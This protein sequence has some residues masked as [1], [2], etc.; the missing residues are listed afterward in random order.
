MPNGGVGAIVEQEG[1]AIDALAGDRIGLV[2]Q[3]AGEGL[4]FHRQSGGFPVLDGEIVGRIVQLKAL[5]CFCLQRVVITGIQVDVDAACAVGGHSVHQPAVL[6]PDLKGGAGDALGAV[7]LGN[8]DKLQPTLSLVEEGQRLSGSAFNEDALRRGIQHIAAHR[9]GFL[10]GDGGAGGQVGDYD[11]AIAVSD[12]LAV[13][14]PH[15]LAGAVRHQERHTLDGVGGAVHI[16]LNGQRLLGGVVKRQRLR[17]RRVDRDGLGAGGRV[18]GVPVDGSG[19]LDHDGAG[20]AGNTD[21]AVGV[22]GVEAV[23]GQVPVGVVHIAAASVGKLELHPGQGLLGHGIQ[24]ADHQLTRP[25]VPEGQ[26]GSA[27]ACLDLNAF[28]DAV[29]HEALHGLDL[30]GGDGGA[31]FQPFNDNFALG[32]GVERAIAGAHRSAAPIHHLKGHTSQR[33][34]GG[35]LDVLMNRQGLLGVI[36][37]GEVIA[38]PSPGAAARGG[39]RIGHGAVGTVGQGVRTIFHNDGLGRGVQ[40]IAAG[41]TDFR[42]HN[43]ATGNK[44]GDGGG[45]VLPGGTAGQYRAA[46]VPHLEG[47]AGDGLPAW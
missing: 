16:F 46:A 44:A 30:A 20:D 47:G 11:T 27:L 21:F 32:I 8:L 14:R 35:A 6:L 23:R 7:G 9:F 18:D 31:G 43:G 26:L 41:H 22:G 10:G 24:L 25:C 45:A 4:V 19:F 39:S 42:H 5:G 13:I 3:N 12:I 37:K 15:I 38:V 34:I 29:Q 1:H 40:H 36:F 2:N 28:G 17:V 33:L